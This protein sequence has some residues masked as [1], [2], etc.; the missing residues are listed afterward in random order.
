MADNWRL[1]V[2]QKVKVVLLYTETKSVVETQ[3]RFRAHFGT[4]WA[5]CKQTIYRLCQQFETNGS[6]LE[7]KQPHPAS[8]RTPANIEAVCVALIR[9]PSKSTRR[10]SAE[11]GISRQSLQRIIHSD[12]HLFPYKITVMHKLTATDKEQRLQFT[13]WAMEEEAVLHN[14]WFTDE[15]YFHLNGVINKQNVRFWARELPHTLHEKENYGAKV[16]VS[17]ANSTHGI[18][19]PF[20]FDDTVTKERYKDMLEN[21]LTLK[22][23]C[24]IYMEHPCLMFLDHTQRRSTVGRTPLDE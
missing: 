18:I 23:L 13:L 21:S 15:A 6:L 1:T 10:A 7:K 3:R 5:P 20:F 11:L 16:N 4:R 24:H 17:T 22:R 8:V 14:T 9:S 19:G 12:L 2:D